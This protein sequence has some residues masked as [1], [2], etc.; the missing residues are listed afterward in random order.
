M[1]H[2]PFVSR[3]VYSNLAWR[4]PA[5][6]MAVGEVS[7]ASCTTSYHIHPTTTARRIRSLTTAYHIHPTTTAICV[8]LLSLCVYALHIFYDV[9]VPWQW[10]RYQG[11]VHYADGEWV[12]VEVE[13][14]GVGKN[15][16]TI[17]A[18]SSVIV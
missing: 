5:Y 3:C 4:S 11:P 18:R 13:D 10:V 2:Y 1:C 12:G 8:P 7:K 9:Y 14:A 16:G 17:K 6:C 15:N